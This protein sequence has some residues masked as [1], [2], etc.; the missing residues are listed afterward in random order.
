MGHRDYTS[1][2]KD[3]SR[4]DQRKAEEGKQAGLTGW[5]LTRQP[6]WGSGVLIYSGGGGRLGTDQSEARRRGCSQRV[7]RQ[8]WVCLLPWL[9]M[10]GSG[11]PAPPRTGAWLCSQE[12]WPCLSRPHPGSSSPLLAA[13]QSRRAWGEVSR[14]EAA[15]T[16]WVTV[17]PAEPRPT[18]RRQQPGLGLWKLP[19]PPLRAGNLMGG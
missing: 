13:A 12:P 10:P 5:R 2:F 6:Q 11:H 16:S 7:E 14:G 9:R 18:A 19:G 8:F 1:V 4:A 3:K 15:A 17:P